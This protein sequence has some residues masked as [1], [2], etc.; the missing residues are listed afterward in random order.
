MSIEQSYAQALFEITKEK[1]NFLLLQEQ[2][3]KIFLMYLS[4][5][6]DPLIC[7]FFQNPC[8]KEVEKIKALEGCFAENKTAAEKIFHQFLL[9]IIKNKRLHDLERIYY[10]FKQ[11]C[12]EAQNAIYGK[13]T[14]S[15]PL[16]KKD[17]QQLEEFFG[18]QFEQK[19]VLEVFEELDL[20][21][22]WKV[23]I[24]GKTFDNTIQTQL[25]KLKAQCTVSK[26]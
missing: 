14:C 21:R 15:H 11:I 24:K 7:K 22:G 20:I 23:T 18:A 12:C 16:K 17:L 10:K 4:V 8:L 25:K 2:I 13:V 26:T 3:K 19:V 1:E 6:L 9:M 5:F